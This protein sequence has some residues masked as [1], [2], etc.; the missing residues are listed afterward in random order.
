[1]LTQIEIHTAGR[2]SGGYLLT[3]CVRS[4]NY[5]MRY[6]F[7]TYA[8]HA[9]VLLFPLGQTRFI[10]ADSP[11]ST[12]VAAAKRQSIQQRRSPGGGEQPQSRRR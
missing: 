9:L 12:G 8:I 2:L 4:Q 7:F 3:I 5:S 11:G 1:M 10:D 6:A